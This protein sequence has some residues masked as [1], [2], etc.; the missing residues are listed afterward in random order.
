MAAKSAWRRSG[1][2]RSGLPAAK[3]SG[4]LLLLSRLSWVTR[5]LHNRVHLDSGNGLAIAPPGNWKKLASKPQ[6]PLTE[7]FRFTTMDLIARCKPGTNS[8]PEP[9]RFTRIDCKAFAVAD[10]RVEYIIE[11]LLVA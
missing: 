7:S 11:N 2:A 3:Q 9:F 1:S 4:A 8:K 5:N 10:Y 6:W